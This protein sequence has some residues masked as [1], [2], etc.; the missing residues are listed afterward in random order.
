MKNEVAIMAKRATE[1]APRHEN[2]RGDVV[3]VID[4]RE[5]FP[6]GEIAHFY[7]SNGRLSSSGPFSLIG[8]FPRLCF[9]FGSIAIIIAKNAAMKKGFA[10]QVL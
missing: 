2:G 9:L 3:V 7:L 6:T 1:R 5:F 10:S 8:V 4:E